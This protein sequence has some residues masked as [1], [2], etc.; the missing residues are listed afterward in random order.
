MKEITNK[1]IYVILVFSILIISIF[2]IAGCSNKTSND[3]IDED[4]SLVSLEAS[5]TGSCDDGIEIS[6]G[7]E[8]I[9]VSAKYSDGS[10]SKINSGWIISEPVTLVAGEISTVTIIYKDISCTL[11][12]ECS[13]PVILTEEQ[14]KEK[15][16][17]LWY[18]DIFF[19]ETDLEGSYVKIDIFVEEFQYYDEETVMYNSI[20]SEFL[21]TYNLERTFYLCGVKRENEDSYV[22]SQISVYFSNNNEITSENFNEGDKITIY[23]KV[24]NYSTNTW[25]GYNTCGILAEYID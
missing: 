20:I 10:I 15:C 9:S 19:S 7:N 12:I 8:N 24:I 3:D 18:D 5:Y 2:T 25:D 11:D 22:G 16:T 17:T 21:S 4:I 13:T 23:G 14:Y 6:D 1:K